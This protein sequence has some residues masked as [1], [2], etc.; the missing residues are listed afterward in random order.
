MSAHSDYPGL[1]W[2]VNVVHRNHCPPGPFCLIVYFQELKFS[3]KKAGLFKDKCAQTW[4][5]SGTNVLEKVPEEPVLPLYHSTGRWPL[6][7]LGCLPSEISDNLFI[8]FYSSP[9]NGIIREDET[10]TDLMA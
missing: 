1:T 2:T 7:Q 5:Y 8:Y 6:H 9:M 10:E 3:R 4:C